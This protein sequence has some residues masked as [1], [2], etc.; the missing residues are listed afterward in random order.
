[1]T[2]SVFWL[3]QGGVWPSERIITGSVALVMVRFSP[4]DDVAAAGDVRRGPGRAK[5]KYDSRVA[6]T[7]RDEVGELARAFN[8]GG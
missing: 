7:S 4:A 1:M 8:N 3:P 2:G 6:A 5:G